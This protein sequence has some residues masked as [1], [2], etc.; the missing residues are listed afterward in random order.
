M[1]DA[2]RLIRFATFEV[3]PVAGELRKDGRK[4]RLQEKPVQLLVLLLKSAGDIVTREQLQQA[5]WPTNTFVDF[6]HGLATAIA[7]VR[8]ALG[9][10]ARSPRFVE[11][12]GGRGYRFIAP[13]TPPA[14]VPSRAGVRLLV[15]GVA[16]LAIGGVLVAVVLGLNVRASDW[17]RRQTNQPVHL[18]AVLPLTNLSNDP[19]QDY[20]VDGMTDQLITTLAQLPGVRVISRV[21]S[22]QYKNAATPLVQIRNALHVD[23]VVQGS[24]I[25]FGNRVRISAQL[26]DARTDQHLWAQSYER[27][28]GDVLGL[29]D[30]IARAVA[31][32]ILV[33]MTPTAEHALATRRYAPAA[34]EAYLLGR[35]QLNK[36]DEAS[37]RQGIDAFKR[38]INL[39]S[40][41]APSYA[42]LAEAYIGLTDFY[43]PPTEM[44]P[45]ARTAAEQ[46]LQIDETL[47]EAHAS[48]GAV[49]FLYEWDW[50]GAEDELKRAV[51]LER[52]SADARV[53]YGIFLAQMGRSAESLAQMREAEVID[54]LSVAVHINAGWA[55]YLARQNDRAIEQ[56]RKALAL[57]PNLATAHTSIWLAYAQKRLPAGDTPAMSVPESASPID[58]A[59]M[60]GVYAVSGRKPEAERALAALE[61]LSAHR[62]VCAYEIATAYAALGQRDNALAWLK[63]GIER[64]SVC[65]PDAQ[66]DPRLDSL[67][68]DPRFQELLREVGFGR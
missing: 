18:L 57:E 7:K 58:L 41:H 48:L 46:A 68:G 32:E 36:G 51:H 14:P 16:G 40:N 64:R 42:G 20:F 47:S 12:V 61:G 62:Y 35:Y 6:D 31:N 44:M 24:V 30:E 56:W 43:E 33:T 8:A 39:D 45:L 49:R 53:W 15:V 22:M 26:V 3:D 25:R 52:G 27:E 50:R 60:A 13:L 17:M 55:Y 2:S 38:A 67:R 28:A 34:Q 66:T 29:Q 21:S 5:L 4:V 10:S 9:D 59:A 63:K 11:T 1:P 37:L 23:A 54:P 19:S 65:M